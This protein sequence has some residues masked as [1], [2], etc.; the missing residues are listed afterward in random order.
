MV[1][2]GFFR[3][4]NRVLTTNPPSAMLRSLST[5]FAVACIFASPSQAQNFTVS[6]THGQAVI[7]KDRGS[8][9]AAVDNSSYTIPAWGK[10]EDNSSLTITFNP[11]NRF[12]LLPNS[13]AQ[14]TTGGAGDSNS[15]WHRVVNLKIGSASFDHST[16]ATPAI[17]LD[18]E[19]PTAVCGAV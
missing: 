3:V 17:H 16:G 6:V 4:T 2:V 14:V 5:L 8:Y 1:F 11:E 15:S 12:R 13:E 7:G 10:T 18:C 9:Q 19:T